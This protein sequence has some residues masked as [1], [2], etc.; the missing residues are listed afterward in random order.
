MRKWGSEEALERFQYIYILGHQIHASRRFTGNRVCS[1]YQGCSKSL[2]KL[3]GKRFARPSICRD[4]QPSQT[5]SE[6]Y[7]FS[8][9]ALYRGVSL[10]LGSIN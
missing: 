2:R 1:F 5:C 10:Y 4:T 9:T 6:G 8:A 3:E 7:T